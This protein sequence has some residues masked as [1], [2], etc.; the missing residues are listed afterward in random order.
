MASEKYVLGI[1]ALFHDSAATLVKGGEILASAQEERFSRKKG[2]WAFPSQAIDYCLTQLPSS[3][4]LDAIAF[5]E[6]PLLKLDRFFKNSIRY[7]PRGAP[8]WPQL[9]RTTNKLNK[10][11][12]SAL[13]EVLNDPEKIFFTSHH[14]AHAASA[15]YVS[16][17][18]KAAVL[19]VDGVGEWSTTSIWLGDHG[20]LYPISEIKFPHSLGLF[21]SAFTQYCGF[22]VNSGEYKLMGLAPFGSPI[23]CK[24]IY[25]EI[26]DVKADGSFALN[27]DYFEF[28]TG[29]STISPLFGQLFGQRMRDPKDPMSPHYRNIAA[30]VQVVLNEVMLSL[31]VTALR[32]AGVKN[33]CMAGGVALNCV[34]NS[35]I[36][37]QLNSLE[38][39]WIQPASGDAG[40]ALGAALEVSQK[41]SDKSREASYV[42]NK[43]IDSMQGSYLG[44]EYTS[45][46]FLDALSN[47]HLVFENYDSDEDGLCEIIVKALLEGAIIGHFD[48]RMEFGPRSLGNRSILADP[49][50]E[51]MRQRVNLKIK[52]RE[53]WR[54]FAPV[55]LEEYSKQYFST[56]NKSPYMLHVADILP[57]YRTGLTMKE[58]HAKTKPSSIQQIT[59]MPFSEFPAITHCDYSARLQTV[60]KATNPRLYQLLQVFFKASQ[61]PMLLNT[62]FNVRGEPVVSSPQDAINCF[63]N[64]HLDILVLGNNIVFKS[65][66]SIAIKNKIGKTKFNDD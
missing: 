65:E 3:M 35:Y 60:T 4:E 27:L 13:Q 20:N 36:S 44:P 24:K 26:L 12:P 38:Q 6:N 2:D 45:K 50:P 52:F 56:P 11:L 1:S 21:Y 66:Q 46:E 30:S 14:R 16:P 8:M 58:I 18:D 15:F 33:L 10:D 5:Y 28:H 32:Q 49:R 22:K 17:F 61:C 62:S 59:N 53:G 64:T 63:L 31:A 34:S 57:K 55:I 23:F 29:V 19:V 39:L 9:L 43:I 37:S 48:G 41:L 51:N 25:D 42:P 40:G 7:A 54:P 47:Q